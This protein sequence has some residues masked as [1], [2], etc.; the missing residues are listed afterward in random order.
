[1]DARDKVDAAHYKAAHARGLLENDAFRD[2]CASVEA[3]YLRRWR[4]TDLSDVEARED[5]FFMLRALD[6]LRQAIEAAARGDKIAAFNSRSS[7]R[8]A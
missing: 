1:M 7:L 4:G 3:E 6:D 8:R 2:A 5:A